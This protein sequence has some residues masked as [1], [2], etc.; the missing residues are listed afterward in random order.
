MKM[1]YKS[2]KQHIWIS[3]EAKLI[4]D[5]RIQ[6]CHY[7]WRGWRVMIDEGSFQGISNVQL[8]DL[9]DS[10]MESLVCDNSSTCILLIC[11]FFYV[12]VLP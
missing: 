2:V 3:Q 12:S 5:V 4:D 7:S 9:S 10:Q 6:D 8:L 11:M 1:D